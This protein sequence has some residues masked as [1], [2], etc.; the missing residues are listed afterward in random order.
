[1]KTKRRPPQ[2]YV[3][4]SLFSVALLFT[5]WQ[6]GNV[7]FTHKVK[8]ATNIEGQ[9]LE[10][11]MLSIAG[12]APK[13]KILKVNGNI[14]PISTD[15][16]WNDSILLPDGYSI[17]TIESKDAYGHIKSDQYPVYVAVDPPTTTVGSRD[18]LPNI[19]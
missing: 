4:T 9:T 12:T 19:N 5:L 13:I 2:F 6:I 15:G 8:L 11:K 14:V 7:V 17:V 16:K 18:S 1:M 10:N 3:T